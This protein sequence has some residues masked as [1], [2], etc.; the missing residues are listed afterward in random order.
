MI[1]LYTIYSNIQQYALI[2]VQ[3]NEKKPR[4]LTKIPRNP[5]NT[6][7]PRSSGKNPA[8]ATLQLADH[9]SSWDAAMNTQ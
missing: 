5:D 1:V 4:L 7:K 8:V 3:L 9:V 6:K 2:N